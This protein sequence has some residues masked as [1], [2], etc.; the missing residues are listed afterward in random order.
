MQKRQAFF[1]W[2]SLVSQMLAK[3]TQKREKGNIFFGARACVKNDP[4]VST[5]IPNSD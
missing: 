1:K 4:L 3:M 5:L 2:F